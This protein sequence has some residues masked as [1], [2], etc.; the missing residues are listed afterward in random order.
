MTHEQNTKSKPRRLAAI[1][2]AL[3]LA[4]A[5]CGCVVEPVGYYGH[6]HYYHGYWR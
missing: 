5:L 4:G 1:V 2:A 3:A 6:P